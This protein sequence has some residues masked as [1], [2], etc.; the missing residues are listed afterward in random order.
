MRESI[1]KL[2]LCDNPIDFWLAMMNEQPRH[3]T[4]KQRAAHMLF[5][6]IAADISGIVGHTCGV[7]RAGKAYKQVLGPLRKSMDEKRAMKS[8][9]Y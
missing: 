4:A 1:A 8:I 5:C 2:R 7:E 3:A 6:K 9:F